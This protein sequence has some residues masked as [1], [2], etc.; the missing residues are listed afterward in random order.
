M[1]SEGVPPDGL[2]TN[3]DGDV[4]ATTY[5]SDFVADHNHERS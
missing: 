5:G 3:A 4:G 2:S 1:V